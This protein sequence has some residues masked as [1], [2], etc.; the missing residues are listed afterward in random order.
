MPKTDWSERNAPTP[1]QPWRMPPHA[2]TDGEHA[3]DVGKSK[4]TAR[5]RNQNQP[6]AGKP[7]KHFVEPYPYTAEQRKTVSEALADCG[8][9]DATA[10]EI[11]IGAIA[12]DLAVLKAALATRTEPQSVA[13]PPPAAAKIAE[14]QPLATRSGSQAERQLA[15]RAQAL[16]QALDA[17]DEPACAALLSALTGSDPF[18]RDYGPAYLG[19]LQVE[20]SRIARAAAAIAGATTGDAGPSEPARGEPEP[21]PPRRKP[22]TARGKRSAPAADEKSALGFIRHAASVYEQCFDAG[23]D[24]APDAAFARM[25]KAVA[26]ATDI[27]IPTDSQLLRRALEQR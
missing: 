6:P 17:L 18:R 21:T 3:G 19:A 15:E 22:A 23:P 1:R 10:R 7:K 5:A 14:R 24:P 2:A 20:V 25:L 9:G 16:L 13:E 8:L 12:Y 27:A 4:R 26:A 11:F